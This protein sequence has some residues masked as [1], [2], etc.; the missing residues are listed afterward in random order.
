[1]TRRRAQ[2]A[3]QRGLPPRGVMPPVANPDGVVVRPASRPSEA[4]MGGQSLWD[5]N[6]G[7]WRY[8]PADQW[9]NAHWDYNDHATP[10][11]P[12]R[13]VSIGGKPPVKG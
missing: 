11:S 1:M 13:N 7:E 10:N 3:T 6:G 2:A 4:A 8:Y 9:H 5:D 12:W